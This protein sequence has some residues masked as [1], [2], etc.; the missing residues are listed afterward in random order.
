MAVK[1]CCMAALKLWNAVAS[2]VISSRMQACDAVQAALQLGVVT[3]MQ[4]IAVQ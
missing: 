2:A 4:W 3:G 1:N